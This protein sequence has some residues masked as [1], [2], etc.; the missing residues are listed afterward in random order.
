MAPHAAFRSHKQFTF[1]KHLAAIGAAKAAHKLRIVIGRVVKQLRDLHAQ[2]SFHHLIS[3]NCSIE[4]MREKR[5]SRKSIGCAAIFVMVVSCSVH[6]ES[7]QTKI[8]PTNIVLIFKDAP[9][10]R[11]SRMAGIVGGYA[12]H[13]I[14][15]VSDSLFTINEV[16]GETENDTIVIS[17]SRPTMEIEHVVKG[18]SQYHYLLSAGDTVVFEYDGFYPKAFRNSDGHAYDLGLNFDAL[19]T[20]LIYRDTFSTVAMLKAF[21]HFSALVPEPTAEKAYHLFADLKNRVE[22]SLKKEQVL[23]DSLFSA[24]LV[25][26]SQFEFHNNKRIYESRLMSLYQT[27][28]WFIREK[29]DVNLV[30]STERALLEI[31][32]DTLLRFA[33]YK[34]SIALLQLISSRKVARMVSVHEGRAGGDVPDFKILYDTILNNN[35][36]P[37]NLKE[38]LLYQTLKDIIQSSKVADVKAYRDRFNHDLVKNVAFRNAIDKEFKLDRAI[39]AKLSLAD[40]DGAPTDLNS[41]LEK[42][43]GRI[44]FVDLWASWCGPCLSA[45]P[46]AL[47]T[48]RKLK[49]KGI[50]FIYISQDQKLDHWKKAVKQF[51]L[52]KQNSYVITNLRTSQF[53]ENL[54]I[55]TIPRYL[56]YDKEGNLVHPN[57]PSPTSAHLEQILLD[58]L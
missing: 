44:V 43:R 8:G 41:V 10:N 30:A 13:E 54:R 49:D 4:I 22:L 38:L 53:L 9:I 11:V 31:H 34:P 47:S 18:F 17:T 1:S 48:S 26:K 16:L 35:R 3:E 52:P 14:S 57:A 51:S 12:T 37:I 6:F 36:L 28:F 21:I 7:P 23:L 15:Y 20:R 50:D 2:V 19:K 42:H 55:Q 45:M 58:Y 25:S 29:L 32:N 24:G 40:D 46:G 5:I 33:H 39:T 56:I 27:N